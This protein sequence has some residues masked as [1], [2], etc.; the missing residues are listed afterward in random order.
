MYQVEVRFKHIKGRE[1]WER[2]ALPEKYKRTC[3]VAKE[4]LDRHYVYAS[5]KFGFES[6]I[7][8]TD[9]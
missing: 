6:R 9:K 2:Y 7:V 8:K 5:S 3:L 4:M 1:K